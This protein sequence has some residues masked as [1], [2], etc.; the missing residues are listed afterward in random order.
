MGGCTSIGVG[1]SPNPGNVSGQF[2]D[3][4]IVNIV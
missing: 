3:A 4:A 2:K 1:Q